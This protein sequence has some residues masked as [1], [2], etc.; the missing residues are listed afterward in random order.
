VNIFL[1]FLQ[2]QTMAPE[3]VPLG[4]IEAESSLMTGTSRQP[5]LDETQQQ[6]GHQLLH[7]DAAIVAAENMRQDAH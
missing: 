1:T 6:R 3:T 4:A 5:P 2:Q 7:R